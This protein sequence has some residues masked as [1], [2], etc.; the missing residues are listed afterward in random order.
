M[1]GWFGRIDFPDGSTTW[2]GNGFNSEE[3]VREYAKKIIDKY[4]DNHKG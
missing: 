3:E 2:T 1:F 4:K